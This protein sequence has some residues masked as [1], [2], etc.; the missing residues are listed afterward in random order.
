MILVNLRSDFLDDDK[1]HVPLGNLYLHAQLKSHGI[2][3]R[4]T[5]S[6]SLTDPAWI[7]SD[8]VGISAL[9]PQRSEAHR[10]AEFVK[11]NSRAKVILGG[12]Y[13]R[14]DLVSASKGFFDF[15]VPRDGERAIV[16]IVR[17]LKDRVVLDEINPMEYREV[18]KKPERLDNADFLAGF[19]FKLN[20]Q[21]ATSLLTARGCPSLCTFCEEART[22]IRKIPNNILF[23][24]IADIKKLG[25]SGVYIFDDTFTL[26]RVHAEPIA[27]ELKRTGLIYRCNGRANQDDTLMKLLADTGCV[28]IAFGAESGNQRILDSVRK[29]TTVEQ[30]YQF[31]K[32]AQSFGMKV[33]AF[34]M[35][36][37]PGENYE[38]M[39]DTERF[40]R[41]SG[42]DSFQL[43]IYYPF[44]GTEIRREMDR[45]QIGNKLDIHLTHEG[46]G[47]YGQRNGK[48]EG[49]VR[50]SELPSEVIVENRD[51]MVKY[52]KRG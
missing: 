34:L 31:V 25:Y 33:K 6:Y 1:V 41:E 5:D 32:R 18:V 35:L 28:E 48:S 26:S 17:G 15:I 37:L 40:I 52:G 42:I 7:D 11:N 16:Q 36:G 22:P 8:F 49:V 50:T 39:G 27:T 51:R 38:T 30:N 12:H 10:L 47:A 21:R 29:G 23:E 19:N 14:N 46:L 9:T 2:K 3:T 4:V 45:G 44:K 43:A 24:E 13:P 20:G